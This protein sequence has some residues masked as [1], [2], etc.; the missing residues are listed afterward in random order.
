M[1][2]LTIAIIA[3]MVLCACGKTGDTGATGATG[4]TG[5]V[6]PQGP[7]APTPTPSPDDPTA[8]AINLL[9]GQYN[10]LRVA[11]G[12][13]PVTNGLTCSLYTVPT[14]TTAIIGAT[15]TGV[16]SW[17]YNSN[18]NVANGPTSNGLDVLPTALQP[19]Y[20]NWYI[21]KCYGEIVNIDDNYHEFSLSSDDGTNLYVDG[22]LVNNDGMHAITTKSATK[23]LSAGVHSFE[24]DYLQGTGSE[25]LILN[26]DGALLDPRFLFH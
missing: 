24:L 6:G 4:Q 3:S 18:F 5:A 17:T 14:T 25:A 26:E 10:N 7:A 8:D 21:V 1:K 12:S 19:I 15:L 2:M 23:F 16:G 13:D 20:Q 9:V 11:Q 22:I